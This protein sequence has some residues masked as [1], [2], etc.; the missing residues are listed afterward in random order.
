MKRNH[1]YMGKMSFPENEKKPSR[2]VTAT[3]IGTSREAIIYKSE[4]NRNGDGKYRSPTVRE[5]ACLMGFPFTYQFLG[6]S[7]SSKCRLV[8]NA[9]CPSISR[10]LAK[11]IRQQL[12]LKNISKPIVRKS[13]NCKDVNNLNSFTQKKFNNSPKKNKGSRFR[14]HPF[15]YGNITVSLSNY[16]IMRKS[17]NGRW[18]TSVQYGNGDGFPCT[19]YPDGYYETLEPVIKKFESGRN[20]IETV[21]KRFSSQIA[22]GKLFQKMYEDQKDENKFIEPTA[23][24]EKVAFLIDKIKFDNPDFKMNGQK[25]FSKTIV[26]KKQI[27][28]LYVINKI[29]SIV[30]KDYRSCKNKN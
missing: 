11:T 12:K 23:L 17:S 6:R 22:P 1:P 28:A 7:E 3:N 13:I 30:N 18:I 25:I 29:C 20:F 24:I 19:V 16:D 21:K 9:V 10:T 15:K 5:M 2:T 26:P 14:R 8:G 4:Y 27:L